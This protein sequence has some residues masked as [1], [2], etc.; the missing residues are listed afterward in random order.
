MQGVPPPQ[1]VA[2]IPM[3]PAPAPAPVTPALPQQGT[4]NNGDKIGQWIN[5]GLVCLAFIMVITS[6][7][8]SNSWVVQEAEILGS[9]METRMGLGDAITTTCD[10]DGDCETEEVDFSEQHE[11]CS[12]DI[13]EMEDAGGS[14]E[15]ADMLKESCDVIGSQSLSGLIGTIV[16]SLSALF[17]LASGALLLIGILGKN[18]PFVKYAPILPG[19]LIFVGF[20]LWAIINPNANGNYGW[21]AN[22]TLISGVVACYT[23]VNP[24]FDKMHSTNGLNSFISESK[25]DL[26]TKLKFVWVGLSFLGLMILFFNIIIGLAVMLI[27][28]VFSL[29]NFA[30][31][32][33]IIDQNDGDEKRM[34]L[35]Q[36]SRNYGNIAPAGVLP[37]NV[38]H[39]PIPAAPVPAAP[40]P[41]APVPAA[42]VPA[43]PVPAAPMPTPPPVMDT[44]PPVNDTPPP[45]LT[46]EPS[47]EPP[48]DIT[49]NLDDNPI[50]DVMSEEQMAD[51]VS[52]IEL[53][54][55][56]EVEEN[57]IVDDSAMNEDQNLQEPEPIMEVVDEP[58]TAQTI[59]PAP[60][61][62]PAPMPT[63]P[64]VMDAPPPAPMPTPPPVM[65]TPPPAP[66]PT[67]PPVMDTPPPAPMPTPPPVMGT[68]PPAPMPTPP[69]AM[70]IPP[71][72]GT[73]L[74]PPISPMGMQPPPNFGNNVQPNQ[75]PQSFAVK[76]APREELMSSEETKD[77][78]NDLFE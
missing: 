40:A 57:N 68:P 19:V 55:A 39:A 30:E 53:T 52:E 36:F 59:P 11:E 49:S 34:L 78:L 38:A 16:F 22:L 56:T 50:T 20:G 29:I 32:K 15:W 37:T 12:D 74:P 51:S 46:P 69:P 25:I 43:P 17:L 26:I 14:S 24:V 66:M 60:T 41:V 7:Y 71:P 9:T 65:D 48:L 2:P 61:P 44:P 58:E 77:L 4:I 21:A 64:P 75:Q 67:P 45:A 27:G 54:N 23:G 73:N 33:I 63:P 1:N 28:I 76:A 3:A 31:P 72:M 8:L 35:L 13:K 18:I 42:P 10:V 5:F 62:P 6:V 47:P 70:A